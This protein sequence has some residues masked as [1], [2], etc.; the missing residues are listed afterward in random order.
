M[1]EQRSTEWRRDGSGNFWRVW[2]GRMLFLFLRNDRWHWSVADSRQ[3]R[4]SE[5]SFATRGEAEAALRDALAGGPGE[6]PSGAEGR[7][8]EL[9][10]R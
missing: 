6:E 7:S 2:R 4:L 3:T 9:A 1:A 5:E 10:L 8:G